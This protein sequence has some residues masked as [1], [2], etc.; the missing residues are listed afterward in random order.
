MTCCPRTRGAIALP[1]ISLFVALLLTAGCSRRAPARSDAAQSQPG[2]IGCSIDGKT[3]PRTPDGRVDLSGFWSGAPPNPNTPSGANETGRGNPAGFGFVGGVMQRH[4]DGSIIYDPSTEYNSESGAGRICVSDDC[5]A[6]NQP[7]YNAEWMEKVRKIAAT[8][9]GGTTPLDPV[10]D[11]RPLGVPRAGVNGIYI[12]QT[13]QVAAILYEAAPYS[14][15][16]LIYTDGRP[17]PKD[18]EP[19]WWGHSIGHWEGDTL[20]VDVV[21]ITDETWLGGGGAVGRTMYTSVHSDKLHVTE[22]WTR[23]GDVLTY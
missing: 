10:Q 2:C 3:A 20:V 15:F 4:P 9:F 17:H 5:Q 14:T 6:P 19:N 8:E 7:P 12:V 18:L 13:P 1:A 11:C 16:R 23:T 21:G 22:R